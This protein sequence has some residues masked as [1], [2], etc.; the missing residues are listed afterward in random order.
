MPRV[1]PSSAF[2][3]QLVTVTRRV[4]RG[5][6]GGV[7][8]GVHRAVGSGS[9]RLEAVLVD[10][11]PASPA[12]YPTGTISQGSTSLQTSVDLSDY[13]S[14]TVWI[15]GAGND[16]ATLKT[17]IASATATVA[18][19]AD[20]AFETVA[21]A[22]VVVLSVANAWILQRA[23]SGRLIRKLDDV[24]DPITKSVVNRFR[25]ISLVADTLIKIEFIDGE[26]QPY[27][28]D[29]EASTWVWPS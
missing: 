1:T 16:G 4:L 12:V 15:D 19:L 28:A 17:T 22:D 23:D 26:W 10:A 27:A 13:V 14:Y 21:D 9:A 6:R 7:G 18:T 11:L 24:G 20:T 3:R 8:P 5:A 25:L 2:N 29:C